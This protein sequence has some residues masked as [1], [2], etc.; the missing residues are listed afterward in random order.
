MKKIFLIFI[1]IYIT[2]FAFAQEQGGLIV[3]TN[4]L[5]LVAKRPSISL[6]K[7]FFNI[8]GLELSYASGEMRHMLSRDYYEYEG[9]L[10]RAKKYL[11]PIEKREANAF[12]GLYVGT[13]KKTIQNQGRSGEGFFDT[14]TATRDFKANSVRFG[15][16]FGVMFIPAKHL[17]LEALTGFGYG[18]YFNM[19]SNPIYSAPP[20]GYLD[21][22]LWLSV[23][24]YF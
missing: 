19:K 10:L 13:L 2:N 20:K 17:T 5:N 3:K 12:Y 14:S 6:E 23:G 8:Y 7:T 21:F 1:G 24:Y 15:G 16:N 4:L 9:F 22:Q 11:V 18:K